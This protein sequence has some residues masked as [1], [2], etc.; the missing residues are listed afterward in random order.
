VVQ[1]KPNQPAQVQITQPPPDMP[2]TLPATVNGR[3]KPGLPRP[4]TQTRFTPGEA[5]RYR[6]QR[7]RVTSW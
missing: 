3:I 7:T 1:P 6:F 5:D 2:I 4:A